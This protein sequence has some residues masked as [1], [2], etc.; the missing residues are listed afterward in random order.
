MFCSSNKRNYWKE[1]VVLVTGGSAGLGEA[2]ARQF[3]VAG[4]KV[5]IAGLE[6]DLLQKT[7][8]EFQAE[9]IDVLPIV[10]NVTNP[11]DVDRLFQ[12]VIA[13]FG[14]LDVLVN[15]AGRTHRGKIDQITCEEILSLMELNLLG[16]VRCSQKAIPF[17]LESRGHL[18]NIGSLAAKSASRWVGAYPMTKFAVAAFSQQ[19]R[20]EIGPQGLHVLLV[21]PGPI[22]RDNPR[23]YKLDNSEGI[24]DSALLP[25]GGVAVSK[26]DPVYLAEK[27]LTACRKRKAELIVP[28]KAK[29]LFALSQ[30]CPA[31]G[32]RIILKKTSKKQ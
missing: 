30:L 12:E 7:A 5:A 24:P 32:D 29:L 9:K 22:A 13:R 11:D 8:I 21:C 31:W 27:I 25:G 23:L 28:A 3:G 14:R 18:V 26:I 17:L 2:I 10:A 6:P 20:L 19:L 16:T 15:A 4:C 1:K